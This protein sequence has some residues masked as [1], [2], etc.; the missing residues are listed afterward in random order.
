MA[1]V[2]TGAETVVE[3]LVAGGAAVA[4]KAGAEEAEMEE[5]CTEWEVAAET[6]REVAVAARARGHERSSPC[7]RCRACTLRIQLRGLRR[8]TIRH[9]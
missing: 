7:S 2:A 1:V 5:G 8:R 3:V 4:R 6:A 9:C